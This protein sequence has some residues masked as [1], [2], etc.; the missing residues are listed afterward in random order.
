MKI[1]HLGLAVRSLDEALTFYREALG[2]RLTA[3]EE[4]ASE[5]V[6]V[7][8]L[9]AGEPRI[10]LLEPLSDGSPVARHL[11]KRGEGLHHVCFEVDDIEAAVQRVRA[12]GGQLVDPAI[13]EG[14][15]GA[16]VAFVHPRT[17]HGLLVELRQHARRAGMSV[18][19]PGAVAILYL[20]EP[21]GKIWG[22]I[23]AM[24]G[25]GV[26]IQGVDLRS[27]EDLLRGAAS[28]DMGPRDL[29]V[30]FYPLRRV[31]KIILDQGSE[32]APSLLD[33]F[34]SRTGSPFMEFL[35][36]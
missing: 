18:P 11:E 17:A 7:A 9:P 28:G 22:V 15:E 14:A 34:E 35:A 6:R 30:I 31:E 8:F 29:S 5:G 12:A 26:S 4:V 21:P 13:R 32:S 33:Q 16:R 25:A 1:D 24:D 3:T 19:C 27:F 23:R 20:L 36:R 10:E 2:L